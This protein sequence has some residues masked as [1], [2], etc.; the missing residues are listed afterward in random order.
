[1]FV[2]RLSSAVS[3]VSKL[4]GLPAKKRNIKAESAADA[5]K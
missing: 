1:M 2:K 3:S 5:L 4:T